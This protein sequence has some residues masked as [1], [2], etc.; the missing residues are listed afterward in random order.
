VATQTKPIM[1]DDATLK[2]LPRG[3]VRGGLAIVPLLLLAAIPSILGY[4]PLGIG[5]VDVN[6]AL[7]AIMSAVA[8]NLLVGYAG[9]LS[10]GHVAFLALGAFGAGVFGLQLGLPFWLTCVASGLL[11]A[12]VGVLVG[13]PSLRLRGLYLLLSSLALHFIGLYLFRKYQIHFFGPAG[14]LYGEASIGPF[15]LSSDTSWFFFLAGCVAVCV[16]FVRNLLLTREGRAFQAVRDADVAAAATGVDV[17]VIKLK[18]FALSSFIVTFAGSLSAYYLASVNADS[19]NLN[20]VVGFYAMMIL[21]GMGSQLGP[22][23]G[24]LVFSFVPTMLLHLSE[25]SAA[26]LP[27][28]G[29]LLT[30]HVNDITTALFGAVILAVL[31]LRPDGLASIGPWLV[32]SARNRRSG[33]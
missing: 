3:V 4:A 22:V 30:S 23:I 27:V 26:G 20:T 9:L 14:I 1:R 25:T 2:V 21:G 7:L 17:P 8:L 18:A 10:M 19:F 29:G 11:G 12:G 13:M 16:L 32:R 15:T 24:A 31:I 28:I 33:R 5:L 6:F